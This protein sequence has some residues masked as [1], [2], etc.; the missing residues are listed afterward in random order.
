MIGKGSGASAHTGIWEKGA[1]SSQ[2]KET[3]L[4]VNMLSVFTYAAKWLLVCKSTEDTWLLGLDSPLKVYFFKNG[5]KIYSVLKYQV[6]CESVHWFCYDLKTVTEVCLVFWGPLYREKKFFRK[7]TWIRHY[8][9]TRL[10]H[11]WLYLSENVILSEQLKCLHMMLLLAFFF[12]Y[13]FVLSNSE[14][15]N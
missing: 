1:I 14:K 2:S 4:L 5:Y 8:V 6:R 13:I 9:Q 10:L 11:L 12:Q 3:L 15:T 7:T